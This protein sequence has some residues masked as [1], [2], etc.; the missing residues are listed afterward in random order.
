MST[1]YK[2]RVDESATPVQHA[3]RQVPAALRS[4]LGEE[5]HHLETT[6]IIAKVEVPTD[7]VS[8][9]VVVPKKN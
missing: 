2:I 1:E 7:W 8:S 4:R 9:M 6:G 3:P 5:L